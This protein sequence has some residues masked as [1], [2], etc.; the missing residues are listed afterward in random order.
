MQINEVLTSE[1]YQLSTDTCLNSIQKPTFL[2]QVTYF[3]KFRTIQDHCIK[4]RG[5][6]EKVSKYGQQKENI[7]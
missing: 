2:C 5:S 3:V 7:D 6:A 4:N 1:C